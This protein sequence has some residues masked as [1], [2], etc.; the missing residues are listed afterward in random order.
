MNEFSLTEIIFAIFTIIFISVLLKNTYI[1]FHHGR[2][3]V[4]VKE[5]KGYAIFWAC[6]LLFWA[7]YLYIG[8]RTILSGDYTFNSNKYYSEILQSITWIEITIIYLLI[9]LRGSQI[10]ENGLYKNGYF[11]KWSKIKSYNWTSPTTIQFE[12]NSF[13]KSG[14][15]FKITIKEE[16]KLKAD[17]IMQKH[18]GL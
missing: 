18:L 10:R 17:E 5:R 12:V 8:V 4:K 1:A 13:L 14:R 9:Y 3:I 7:V 6:M 2:L 16:L 11:I 15:N